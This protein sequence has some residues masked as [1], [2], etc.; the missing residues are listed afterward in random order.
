[1]RRVT[2]M[3][4]NLMRVRPALRMLLGVSLAALILTIGANPRADAAAGPASAPGLVVALQQPAPATGDFVPVDELPAQEKL[5]A[6]PLL[7]GAYVFVW[8]ALL[9]YVFMLWRRLSRVEQELA[10]LARQ[11]DERRRN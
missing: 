3:T 6:G 9:V 10:T 4:G 11:V 5:P 8:G 2:F 1:M 7:I